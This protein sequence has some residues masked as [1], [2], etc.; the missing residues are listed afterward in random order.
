M[1]DE[2][3][4]A[5]H[6]PAGLDIGARTPGEIALSIAAEIVSLR[7]GGGG[8]VAARSQRTD[9]RRRPAHPACALRSD[10]ASLGVTRYSTPSMTSVDLT[11]TVT[12]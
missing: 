10:E 3:I 2:A 6:G 12:A 8:C 1:S 11:S 4:A 7:S 9:P 5:I